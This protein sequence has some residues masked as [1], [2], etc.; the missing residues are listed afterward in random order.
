MF[1]VNRQINQMKRTKQDVNQVGCR[2][3]I[4]IEKL[5]KSRGERGEGGKNNLVKFAKTKNKQVAISSKHK[6]GF[7]RMN[8]TDLNI[9][10]CSSPLSL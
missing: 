2:M 8:G 4:T 7:P 6:L 5:E 1:D 3:K 10:V 9:S